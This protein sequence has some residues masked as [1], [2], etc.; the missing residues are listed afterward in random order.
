MQ[1]LSSARLALSD[2]ILAMKPVKDL[3]TKYLVQKMGERGNKRKDEMLRELKKR[4]KSDPIAKGFMKEHDKKQRAFDKE[5]KKLDDRIER[6]KQ[7]EEFKEREQ[8]FDEDL[9]NQLRDMR[10]NNPGAYKRLMQQYG[11]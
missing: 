10:K 6:R 2:A 9:K 7:D 3:S 11:L 4:A 5:M 8:R 1:I